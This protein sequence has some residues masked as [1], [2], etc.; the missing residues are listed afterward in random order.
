MKPNLAYC[1]PSFSPSHATKRVC[2]NADHVIEAPHP[3]GA[4]KVTTFARQV[5]CSNWRAQSMQSEGQ[6]KTTTCMGSQS[7]THPKGT[8]KH[9][10]NTSSVGKQKV[11][12]KRPAPYGQH[13]AQS[14][15]G[16]SGPSNTCR[17]EALAS[18]RA[19]ER[20][21]MTPALHNNH[22]QFMLGTSKKRSPG[23]S[24]SL[25]LRDCSGYG[26]SI[27]GTV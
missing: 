14:R 15:K 8:R 16:V 22:T 20:V 12:T 21:N 26:R 9:R 24:Q 17:S 7:C 2:R 5:N 10:N 27:G 6:R 11:T 13:N 23:Y 19:Q 3:L 25:Q 18:N 4:G 1:L